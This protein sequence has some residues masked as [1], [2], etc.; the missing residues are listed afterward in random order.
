MKAKISFYNQGCRLNQAETSALSRAATFGPFEVVDFLEP[1]DIVVVNTCTVTENGD[2]DTRRLVNK[3]CR[4]NADSKIALIGC[5]AQ[6]KKEVLFQLPNVKWVIGNQEKMDLIRI[7]S[8]PL[9]EE[10]PTLRVSKITRES[11]T[12]D[13]S[14]IDDKHT[15]ANLKIQDG[16]DFYCAFCVIPFARGPARSRRFLDILKEAQILADAG[17]QEIV[18]TGV[19]LATYLDDGKTFEDVVNALEAVDGIQ[20]I[21]ISSI[22]P[23]TIPSSLIDR[24]A[25]PRSKVCAYL[26]IPIQ[27]GTD[28]ILAGMQRK[29]TLSEFDA[30]IQDAYKR[31][32]GMCIGTDVIVGFPG[33]T[34]EL[35]DQTE[36]YLRDAPIHYFHVFSYSERKMARSKKLEGQVNPGVIARRSERLRGLSTRKRRA[37]Y[38]EALG[39][40]VS[41]L[42]EQKK[43]EFWSG[44]SDEFIRVLVKSDLDLKN[45]IVDVVLEKVN[46]RGCVGRV[47]SSVLG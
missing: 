20:R 8:E 18:L 42:F 37:F 9:D 27:S 6:V 39:K 19:N 11:F 23:T 36:A 41:V 25:D 12:L 47:D 4:I 29:Y 14:A 43:G 28:A 30:F 1:A 31:V 38:T 15:R 5:Q 16:C 44:V 32:P 7:L 40:K 13:V 10:K 33:E 26:H 22:E 34:D 3:I 35:F 24:M 21:R 46:D 2:A 17:H 45:K